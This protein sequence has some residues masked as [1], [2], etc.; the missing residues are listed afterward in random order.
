M[1]IPA[2]RRSRW[3]P[4]NPATRLAGMPTAITAPMTSEQLDAYML[5]VRIEDIMRHL[6]TDDAVSTTITTSADRDRRSLSP[7]PQYDGAGRRINTRHR[8]HR[9]RLEQKRHELVRPAAATIPQYRAP[10]GYHTQ[11]RGRSP[12]A[13]FEE[14]V[15][16]PSRDFP[17][18]NFIGQLLGPRG[19]SLADMNAES[20]AT[21]AIR[22]RG[23]TKEG[24]TGA[25]GG[26]QYTDSSEPLH[27]LI[28]ADAPVKVVRAKKLVQDVI[29]G[30][31]GTPEHENERKRRQLRDLAVVNGT[32]RDDEGRGLRRGEPAGV[33][34]RVCGGGHLSRDCRGS[35]TTIAPWRRSKTRTA[36][37]DPV[38]VECSQFLSEL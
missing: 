4:E 26:R 16:I 23:S 24:R 25:R 12:R 38:D 3:G 30:A 36:T 9:E 20:G 34:C 29:E 13:L 19:R 31:V 17:E 35:G 15:Y 21:I 7:P 28:T 33:S 18:I 14:K 22:G 6:E 11:A 27:C 5:H 2:V 8:R 1:A 10:A 32:F 37:A